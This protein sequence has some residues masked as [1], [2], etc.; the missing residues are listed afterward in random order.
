MLNSNSK[1]IYCV[2]D[3]AKILWVR[4]KLPDNWFT[5]ILPLSIKI[6][7]VELTASKKKTG[8][9]DANQRSVWM[10]RDKSVGVYSTIFSRFRSTQYTDSHSKKKTSREGQGLMQAHNCRGILQQ[11]TAKTQRFLDCLL[12][13]LFSLQLKAHLWTQN[14]TV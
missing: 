10:Y 8:G 7:L 2:E 14:G 12:R 1:K 9:G 6:Y 4:K 11:R 13:S 3:N 5:G